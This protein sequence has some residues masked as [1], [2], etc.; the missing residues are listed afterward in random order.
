MP[1]QTLY[2]SWKVRRR[3]LQRATATL[4]WSIRKEQ[5]AILDGLLD[6]FRGS[7][8]ARR[9]ARFP[10]I[11]PFFKA[12]HAKVARLRARVSS[13]KQRAAERAQARVEPILQDIAAVDPQ[14]TLRKNAG[15]Y[16]RRSGAHS[17]RLALSAEAPVQTGLFDSDLRLVVAS[18]FERAGAALMECL[19]ERNPLDAPR[20][21]LRLAGA[22]VKGM[23]NIV[24]GNEARG[25]A[26]FVVDQLHSGEF[27]EQRPEAENG[28]RSD[29]KLFL[30]RRT[31]LLHA[32]AQETSARNARL[33]PEDATAMVRVARR[34]I[35]RRAASR[36]N[37]SAPTTRLDDVS[38]LWFTRYV[39][40]MIE[41][42]GEALDKVAASLDQ[43]TLPGED[44]S[45]VLYFH[46]LCVSRAMKLLA[47]GP[48]QRD[49][50]SPRLAAQS[51]DEQLLDESASL[52][53]DPAAREWALS[54]F[55]LDLTSG[56]LGVRI[57][58]LEMISRLGTLDDIGL[59]L[60]V[61]TLLPDSPHS[62]GSM[63]ERQMILKAA[64]R[65][66]LHPCS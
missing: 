46:L 16:A 11:Q 66:A 57:V 25:R 41:G 44:L 24:T 36:S 58:A 7:E 22:Y 40:R 50:A 60:D 18:I 12:A 65:L 49:A 34:F 37:S 52:L 43:F 54:R 9:P 35:Q 15:R 59:L 8:T 51:G 64:R 32:V 30:D 39:Q 27:S 20:K 33:S 31:I 42:Q 17:G 14:S 55:R 38:G 61:C 4:K 56:D 10:S 5:I 28:R 21:L 19:F 53:Q 48:D 3:R 26:N 63:E 13:G 29:D 45:K 1:A 62:C 6:K 47:E 2:Q 23:C